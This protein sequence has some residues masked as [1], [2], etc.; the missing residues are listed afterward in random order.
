MSA[1]CFETTRRDEIARILKGHADE[2]VCLTIVAHRLIKGNLW[3]VEEQAWKADSEP[4]R[5]IM[6]RSFFDGYWRACPESGGP[7]DVD[8]PLEFLDM[9]P[10][11]ETQY[12]I[13]WRDKVR[14]YHEARKKPKAA[15]REIGVAKE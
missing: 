3:T 14:A 13:G 7:A 8:C 4:R 15:A 12:S 1:H 10:D 9:A 11:P 2:S 5:C 6:V